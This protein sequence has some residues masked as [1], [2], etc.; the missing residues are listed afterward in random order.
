MSEYVDV[1]VMHLSMSI[2]RGEGGQTPRILTEEIYFVRIPP[3]RHKF[4]VRK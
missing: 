3:P 1:D 4:L 2:R